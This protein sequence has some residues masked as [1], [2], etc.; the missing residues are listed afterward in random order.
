MA[1]NPFESDDESYLA[2]VNDEGQYSLW[3]Q[4]IDVPDGWRVAFGAA[5]RGECLSYI[6]EVWQDMRPTSL[7]AR[8]GA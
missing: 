5:T 6:E 7:I 8:S 1:T 2:L 3:P 4:R